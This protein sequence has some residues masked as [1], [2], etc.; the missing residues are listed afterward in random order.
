[1]GQLA[2]GDPGAEGVGWGEEK[3]KEVAKRTDWAVEHGPERKTSG[4]PESRSTHI[5]CVVL[6]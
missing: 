5:E 2:C 3:D 1:M 4:R 6:R